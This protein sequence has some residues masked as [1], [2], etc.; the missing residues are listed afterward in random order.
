MTESTQPV[1]EQD[2]VED[3][4]AFTRNVF[5]PE[6]LT[7][8]SSPGYLSVSPVV[9]L[10]IFF[11]REVSDCSEIL[12]DLRSENTQVITRMYSAEKSKIEL[13]HG[14]EPNDKTQSQAFDYFRK[15]II[16][17]IINNIIE[18][19]NVD[20]DKMT[21]RICDGKLSK[22]TAQV[23]MA[24]IGKAFDLGLGNFYFKPEGVEYNEVEKPE[25]MR[26]ERHAAR[27]EH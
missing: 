13:I 23:V 19:N 6:L 24:P 7:T 20:G 15:E 14:I 11:L 2:N 8:T 27:E 26:A 21:E 16:W 1:S 5:G 25:G 10:S 4:P 22:A 12:N 18:Q 9:P 17:V 3:A